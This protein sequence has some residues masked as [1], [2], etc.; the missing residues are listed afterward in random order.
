MDFADNN[1][2]QNIE[3]FRPTFDDE[4]ITNLIQNP[5]SHENL[6]DS[7]EK[8]ES[9]ENVD[10]NLE[11]LFDEIEET[12]KTNIEEAKRMATTALNVCTH[13]YEIAGVSGTELLVVKSS[14]QKLF[15][16][17]FASIQTSLQILKDKMD[18]EEQ[19][20]RD[21]SKAELEPEFKELNAKKMEG[22]SRHMQSYQRMVELY[23]M[24]ELKI[25]EMLSKHLPPEV[26]AH[27]KDEIKIAA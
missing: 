24:A 16:T 20:N 7:T 9:A 8:K 18:Y 26:E 21:I 3:T 25:R 22:V 5:E 13:Y 23:H 11:K 2:N 4:K 12:A 15:D 27:L 14:V 17:Y 10:F 19:A 6:K 1:L